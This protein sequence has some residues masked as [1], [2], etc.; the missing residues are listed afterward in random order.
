[1]KGK[2]YE[3]DEY[4]TDKIE[5]HIIDL[6]KFKKMKNPKGELADWL[7]L[8]LGNEGAIEMAIQRNADIARVNEENKELSEAKD[9][10]QFLR[11]V[12]RYDENTRK[13]YEMEDVA[14][15]MLNIGMKLKDI[16]EVTELSKEEIEK[17]MENTGISK[18]E[19]N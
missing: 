16:Q 15:K 5:V 10:A 8:I 2:V 7:N 19:N 13:R 3:K 18:N 1:M 4:I 17:L 14:K 11:D 12:A 9:W 6:K